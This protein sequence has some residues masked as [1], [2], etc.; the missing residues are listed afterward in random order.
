MK[1]L[2]FV[3]AI[4]FST[5]LYSSDKKVIGNGKIVNIEKKVDYFNKVSLNGT[6]TVF[7]VQSDTFS[8]KIE[9]DENIASLYEPTV[10]NN[11][12]SV[13]L[14]PGYSIQKGTKLNIF[15]MTKEINQV[16]FSSTGNIEIGPFTNMHNFELN[17][18]ST[19]NIDLQS[20]CNAL[21][22]NNRG[23]GTLKFNANANEII[24]NN[25]A[26]GNLN[27]PKLNSKIIS[28]YH[29]GTGSINLVGTCTKL[30]IKH[31]GT[32]NIN[33]FELIIEE[34]Q[35]IHN[36]TGKV[37]LTVTKELNVLENNSGSIR[38]MGPAILKRV[39]SKGTLK[40]MD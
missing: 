1:T 16:T 30:D 2:I 10:V 31:T 5:L 20:D 32:G 8:I 39:N 37:D 15:I 3:A 12:L 38:Y 23:T 13:N 26:T 18:H 29:S 24:I 33:A 25:S 9:A 7:I 28:I 40:K 22:I 6:Y 21:L 35:I 17:N 27:F 4:L 34:S 11:T 19:G 14:K 36:G